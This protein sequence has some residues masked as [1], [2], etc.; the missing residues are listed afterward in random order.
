VAKKSTQSASNSWDVAFVNMDLDS[1]QKLV[2]AKW[3][4]DGSK[5]WDCIVGLV[6][7]GCKLSVSFDEA[8]DT[9]IC[10][11]TRPKGNG[12]ARSFCLVARGPDISKA[13]RSFGY[14]VAVVLDGDFDSAQQFI[15]R[16]S[17]WE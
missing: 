13:L 7:E 6:A 4:V 5:S 2:M 3:D 8:N 16:R 1:G 11:V 10:A 17:D 15:G 12:V 9:Y 14:R